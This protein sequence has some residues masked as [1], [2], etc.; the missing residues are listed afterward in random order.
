MEQR[1]IGVSIETHAAQPKAEAHILTAKE[2]ISAYF[3]IAAA[4]FGLIS[5][6]CKQLWVHGCSC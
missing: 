2:T 5:D 1:T 3:T 6:G 4:A